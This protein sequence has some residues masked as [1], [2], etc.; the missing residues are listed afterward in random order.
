MPSCLTAILGQ[1]STPCITAQVLAAKLICEDAVG[2]N[3]GRPAVLWSIT[4]NPTAAPRR[5]WAIRGWEHP[6]KTRNSSE[7]L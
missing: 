1:L 4:S 7:R 3:T 2:V 5:F 6:G